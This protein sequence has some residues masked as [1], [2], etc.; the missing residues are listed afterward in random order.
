MKELKQGEQA[1]LEA[2]LQARES[3]LLG[4]LAGAWRQEAPVGADGLWFMIYQP[5][6]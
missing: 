6:L 3:G 4:F 2:L 1:V 5:C